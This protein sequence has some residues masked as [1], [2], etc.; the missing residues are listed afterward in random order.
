MRERQPGTAWGRCYTGIHA[1]FASCPAG[2]DRR[3][4]CCLAVVRLIPAVDLSGGRVV[5]A[6]PGT[7]ADYPPLRSRL[8]RSAEPAAVVGALLRLYPFAV[9]YLADL[10]ALQG[11]P[12]TATPARLARR[13]PRVVFWLDAGCHTVQRR[14]PRNLCRVYGSETG[15]GPLDAAALPHPA[16]LSLDFRNGRLWGDARL[17]ARPACWPRRVILMDLDRT[18]R[19]RG[20]NRRRV[21]WLRRMVG[22]GRE[23]YVAGGV[24][25][26][27]DLRALAALGVHG[28]LIATAVHSGRLDARTLRRLARSR[29]APD[30]PL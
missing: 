1:R 30:P 23:L 3:A 5:H 8:C 7:R 10:D 11:G 9:I 18:G 2:P 12:A 26:V 4:A 27:G 20:A 25:H 19:R 16:V 29:R 14:R 28:A 22:P 21:A 13:F 15:L 6:G 17:L 24:R